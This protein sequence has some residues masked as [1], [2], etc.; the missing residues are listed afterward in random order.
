MNLRAKVLSSGKNLIY[1]HVAS[2][3]LS[4][5]GALFFSRTLGVRDFAIYA[6]CASIT[7]VLRVICRVG[8]NARLL[9]KRS[10]PSRQQYDVTLAL[11]LSA[12]VV[13]G[14]FAVVLLPFIET[15]SNTRGFFWPG[16]LTVSL[17]PLSVAA[18]PAVTRLER[19]LAFRRV[20]IIETSCQVFG[21]ATGIGLAMIGWGIWGPLTGWVV[22]DVANLILSWCS[23]EQA[24]RLRW[25]N[26][27]V[28]K[29]L[30]FGVLYTSAASLNQGRTLVLLTLIGRFYGQDAVGYMA[31]TLRAA[32]LITPFRSSASRVMLPTLAGVTNQ[33]ENRL[34]RMLSLAARTEVLLSIPIAVIATGFY[35]FGLTNL[36]G[37]DWM[38]TVEYFP[39]VVSG[40]IISATHGLTLTALHSRAYF[41]ESIISSLAICAAYAVVIKMLSV[42]ALTPPAMCVVLAWP[43]L[44]LQDYFC[45]RLLAIKI[46]PY[47]ML[48]CAAGIAMCLAQNYGYLLLAIPVLVFF[49]TRVQI[50]SNMRAIMNA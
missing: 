35:E 38:A 1:G 20:A 30:K 2:S 3:F 17:V 11:M 28:F 7:G 22:R 25:R 23:V 37:S 12:S 26:K 47:K 31:L 15:I 10:E 6:L 40:V 44:W 46:D 45:L 49:A 34:N 19:S 21:L 36:L 43:M 41:R 4:L 16:L 32:N 18:V 50:L 9:T 48:W 39:W 14:T 42:Y 13:F 33:S 27:L 5:C 29:I 24:P 8:A